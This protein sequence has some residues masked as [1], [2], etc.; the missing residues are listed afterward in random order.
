MATWL[1]PILPQKWCDERELAVSRR[2][3]VQ[4]QDVMF[5]VSVIRAYDIMVIYINVFTG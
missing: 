2:S 5:S 1:F 3:G 4:I